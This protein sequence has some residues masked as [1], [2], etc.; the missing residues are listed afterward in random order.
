MTLTGDMLIGGQTIA[1][2][3]DAIHAINP[4]TDEVLAPGYA[5]GGREQVEQACALAWAAF[6]RYRDGSGGPRPLS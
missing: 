4:A 1:G 6:D 2:N 3:R 5:G